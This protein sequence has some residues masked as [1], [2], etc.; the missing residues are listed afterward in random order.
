MTSKLYIF[1]IDF[2]QIIVSTLTLLRHTLPLEYTA[3]IDR[4]TM[5]WRGEARLPRSFFPPDVSLFNAFAIH[6]TGEERKYQALYEVSGPQPD[7]HRI[8]KFQPV[9]FSDIL[10]G[11]KGS[12]LSPLWKVSIEEAKLNKKD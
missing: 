1:D 8:D 12:Q 7:F 4:E 10:P 5:T 3:S 2:C 11:N 6:G 9:D